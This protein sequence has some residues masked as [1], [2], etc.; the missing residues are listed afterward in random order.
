[1]SQ[2]VSESLNEW[3]SQW[4]NNRLW[5]ECQWVNC[6]VK[7]E[8]RKWISKWISERVSQVS[9]WI[10]KWIN[11]W[12]NKFLNQWVSRN[13]H[14]TVHSQCTYSYTHLSQKPALSQHAFFP[15]SP[16]MIFLPCCCSQSFM[17]PLTAS[18]LQC[19]FLNTYFLPHSFI[20][21]SHCYLLSLLYTLSSFSP[22][23]H[24]LHTVGQ[25]YYEGNE[26]LSNMP[27]EAERTDELE[28]EVGH[29]PVSFCHFYYSHLISTQRDCL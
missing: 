3:V 5:I 24:S 12:V 7:E 22:S 29:H 27:A 13:V 21:Y 14:P 19:H 25:E 10:N 4:V 26:Y 16:F 9:E 15:S 28:Y 23:C 1:M 2:S 6:W 8:V 18:F 20:V 17:T 11:N